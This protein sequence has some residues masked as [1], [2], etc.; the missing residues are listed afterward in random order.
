MGL[1]VTVE[2]KV[3]PWSVGENVKRVLLDDDVDR[4]CPVYISSQDVRHHA[5]LSDLGMLRR[6]RNVLVVALHRNKSYHES[7]RTAA[8]MEVSTRGGADL[9]NLLELLDNIKVI[10]TGRV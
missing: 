8:V 7:Y 4:R 9:G 1:S 6:R 2:C 3:G 5:R 10:D